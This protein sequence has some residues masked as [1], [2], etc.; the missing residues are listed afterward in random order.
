MRRTRARAAAVAAV[1]VLASFVAVCGSAN[2]ANAAGM[3]TM[4]VELAGR[5][6]RD[7]AGERPIELHPGH[8]ILLRVEATN[9]GDEPV[10]IRHVVLAGEAIGFQFVTYDVGLT[11]VVAPGQTRVIRLPLDL[12]DLGDQATGYLAAAVRLY[13]GQHR[14]L[15]EQRFVM[16]V[17]GD[18]TSTLGIFAIALLVISVFCLVMLGLRLYRRE[19]SRNRAMR[20]FQ[21][22]LAGA[23]VG[24]LLALGPPALRWSALTSDGWITLLVGPMAIGFV[25][26]YLAPGPIS[27]TIA[28]AREDEMLDIVASQALERISAE[29]TAER[30]AAN[31]GRTGETVVSGSTDARRSGETV[32]SGSTDARRSGET[33]VSG[34]TDARRSSETV[35]TGPTDPRR[36]GETVVTGAGAASDNDADGGE[37]DEAP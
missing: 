17:D 15:A 28:D 3:V 14:L 36:S 4:R 26:G 16:D 30:A 19:L 5:H 37:P 13:D 2:P 12:Y 20:G 6:V 8:R 9:V 21:F 33:V 23:A 18:W 29:H 11:Q 25:L 27:Y 7:R 10:T 24:L 34:P 1:L 32:V 31:G 22:M 35:V